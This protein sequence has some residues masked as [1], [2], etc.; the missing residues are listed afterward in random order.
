ML[1]PRHRWF[2]TIATMRPGVTVGT[3]VKQS[4]VGKVILEQA[5]ANKALLEKSSWSSYH[6]VTKNDD[7]I[8][9]SEVV[10][11]TA[12]NQHSS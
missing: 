8:E 6:Q 5:L 12:E 9:F 4:P 7:S 11:K 2:N 10:N 3:V 1:E